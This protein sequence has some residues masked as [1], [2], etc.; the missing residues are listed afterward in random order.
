MWVVHRS[1][2]AH[3]LVWQNEQSHAARPR[4]DDDFFSKSPQEACSRIPGQPSLE[5]TSHFFCAFTPGQQI[6]LQP[7][8]RR[9]V[10]LDVVI[11]NQIYLAD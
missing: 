3:A 11:K 5:D 6:E 7:K 10:L 8:T 1:K 9:C 4:S 2:E